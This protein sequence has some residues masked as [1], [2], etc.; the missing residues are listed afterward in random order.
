MNKADLCFQRRAREQQQDEDGAAG[1]DGR[2]GE[3][4]GAGVRTGCLQPA[5]V[6]LSMNTNH[7]LLFVIIIMTTNYCVAIIYLKE[8]EEGYKCDTQIQH[9]TLSFLLPSDLFP[10]LAHSVIS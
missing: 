7:S 5:L 6:D 4:R 2:T 3:I 8:D 9:K 10:F 1:P